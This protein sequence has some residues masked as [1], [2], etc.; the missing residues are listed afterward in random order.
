MKVARLR[1]R[2]IIK[3]E[4]K[5]HSLKWSHLQKEGHSVVVIGSFTSPPWEKELKLDFCKIRK[6]YVKYLKNL[7]HGRFEFK[8]IVDG[9]YMCDG[10][11]PTVISREGVVNNYFHP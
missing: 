4:R 5:F 11:L 2:R 10:K 8:F 7:P 9:E 3:F 1:Y 6:I